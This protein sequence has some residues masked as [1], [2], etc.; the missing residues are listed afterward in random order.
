MSGCK[1]IAEYAVKKWMESN[2]F[3][4]SEF[5]VSMDENTAMITD[6]RGNC[7]KVHYNPKNRRVEED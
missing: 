1:T 5:A 2:G 3:I 6:K 4:M 7:L